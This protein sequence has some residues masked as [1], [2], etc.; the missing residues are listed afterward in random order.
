[1]VA[2][3]ISQSVEVVSGSILDD[4]FLDQKKEGLDREDLVGPLENGFSFERW[5]LAREEIIL[6]KRKQLKKMLPFQGE[7]TTKKISS[8][9]TL[10][11]LEDDPRVRETRKKLLGRRE[12]PKS[13]IFSS[14]MKIESLE[15]SLTGSKLQRENVKEIYSKERV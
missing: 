6:D 13:T 2:S 4:D 7:K 3:E 1:M 5:I 9:E 14:R 12:F 11:T 10:E 15:E 8:L